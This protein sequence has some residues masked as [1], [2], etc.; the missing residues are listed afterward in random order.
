MTPFEIIDIGHK[1][2]VKEEAEKKTIELLRRAEFETWL[3]T[4]PDL[5]EEQKTEGATDSDERTV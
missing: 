4:R 1:A 3:R 5:T 2:A